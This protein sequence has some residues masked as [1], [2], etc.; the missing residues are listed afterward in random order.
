MSSVIKSSQ[1]VSK[2]YEYTSSTLSKSPWSMPKVFKTVDELKLFVEL[3]NDLIDLN[4]Q[5]DLAQLANDW[6]SLLKR[7]YD[8]APELIVGKY[9][10]K[11]VSIIKKFLLDIN[12]KMDC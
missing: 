10:L 8:N 2:F 11:N 1:T 4:G 9:Y 5:V 7:C 12:I 6:N 3:H